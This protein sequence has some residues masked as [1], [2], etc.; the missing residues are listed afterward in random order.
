MEGIGGESAE[1]LLPLGRRTDATK[2]NKNKR[3]NTQL[4][5][6]KR[7]K[8]KRGNTQVTTKKLSYTLE[9]P[10]VSLS[11][12][13]APRRATRG[14]NWR[15]VCVGI[16]TSGE[17]DRRDEKKISAGTHNSQLENTLRT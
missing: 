11:L 1:E 15:R 6:K 2:K 13:N 7:K 5:T 16:A 17:T 10:R 4:T 12:R 3:G 8:K 9:N 14:R